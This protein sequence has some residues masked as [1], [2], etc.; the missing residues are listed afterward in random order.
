M[1]KF[2]LQPHFNVPPW[3]YS[4]VSPCK[5][6]NAQHAACGYP[7]LQD[8]IREVSGDRRELTGCY[9]GSEYSSPCFLA[10]NLPCILQGQTVPRMMSRILKIPWRKTGCLGKWQDLHDLAGPLLNCKLTNRSGIDDPD[11]E[12]PY[13]EP[14]EYFEVP[15]IHMRAPDA[16]KLSKDA[17]IHDKWPRVLR[18]PDFKPPPP[19][20]GGQAQS[21]PVAPPSPPPS[22]ED[23]ASEEGPASE[24]APQPAS[25]PTST[26]APVPTPPS[27]PTPKIYSLPKCRRC[28]IRGHIAVCDSPSPSIINFLLSVPPIY[29][30][31][32]S[33]VPI[34]VPSK[35]LVSHD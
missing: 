16:Y 14:P 29:L 33:F 6:S 3:W 34:F 31:L 17:W 23:P 9:C 13:F 27:S 4:H 22:E 15:G 30:S 28:K 25:T 10:W 18:N 35:S 24:K 5:Q 11:F 20:D 19:P 1:A 26:P 7:P 12:P 21:H 32:C 2:W 8:G